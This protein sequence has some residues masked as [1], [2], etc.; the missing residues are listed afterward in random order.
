VDALAQVIHAR[1]V[2]LPVLVEHVEHHVL[3]QHAHGLA[4]DLGFLGLEQLLDRL[5]HLRQDLRRVQLVLLLVHAHQ[6]QLQPNSV[7][8]SASRPGRSHWSSTESAGTKRSTRSATTS[9]RMPSMLALTL[10]ASSNSSRWP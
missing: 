10:S 9:L 8:S 5:L 4:T 1:Q 7:A 2:F 6:R 3:L